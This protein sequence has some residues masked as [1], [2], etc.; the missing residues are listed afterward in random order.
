MDNT[1]LLIDM[2][3]TFACVSRVL[4]QY[5]ARELKINVKD[6]HCYLENLGL[7]QALAE[8]V[9]DLIIQDLAL[10]I[11]CILVDTL[12]PEMM[13]GTA[14]GSQGRIGFVGVQ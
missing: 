2:G 1:R 6:L 13:P 11:S 8:F 4:S 7:A 12:Q 5:W 14:S 9:I 3:D 10:G